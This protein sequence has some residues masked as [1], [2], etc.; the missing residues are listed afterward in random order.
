MRKS[1]CVASIEDLSRNHNY[2]NAKSD[3]SHDREPRMS[4]GTNLVWKS[5]SPVFR[6]ELNRS[7]GV[8]DGDQQTKRARHNWG[9]EECIG[10]GMD[11]RSNFNSYPYDNKMYPA[12]K[13]TTYAAL[14]NGA[15][16]DLLP[17]TLSELYAG[18]ECEMRI[19]VPW[20][21][22]RLLKPRLRRII[23]KPRNQRLNPGLIACL[24]MKKF[25]P[26]P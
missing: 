12:I 6:A 13:G 1:G 11:L 22:P 24:M 15:G 25:S 8:A 16:T 4:Q 21:S 17:A 3:P 7:M 2:Q 20:F 5:N 26:A 19:N 9:L 18:T 23:L 14:P 10:R